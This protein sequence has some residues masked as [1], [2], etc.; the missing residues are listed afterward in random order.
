M[1]DIEWECPA[2]IVCMTQVHVLT[3]LPQHTAAQ[4]TPDDV[5]AEIIP[6]NAKIN[7]NAP[8]ARLTCRKYYMQ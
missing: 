8:I 6:T 3:V 7:I 4:P 2:S 1:M 5:I